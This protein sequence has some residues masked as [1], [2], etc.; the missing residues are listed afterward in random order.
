MS[1]AMD[2]IHHW[3]DEVKAEFE[4]L[5]GHA[6]TEVQSAAKN[7]VEK[8]DAVKGELA[9]DVPALEAEA[10]SDAE[11]VVKTAETQGV[12]PAEREAVADAAKL[13]GKVAHD[14]E[15]A[16]AAHT[17]QQTAAVLA[18]EAAVASTETHA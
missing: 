13:G 5:L 18:G 1:A 12:V 3:L 2:R 11:S 4:H 10:K 8:I 9:A 16:V 6:D 17:P 14:V 7:A 15:T